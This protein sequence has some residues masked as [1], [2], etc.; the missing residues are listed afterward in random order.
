MILFGYRRDEYGFLSNFWPSPF[1]AEGLTWPTVEHFFQAMKTEDR[2]IWEIFAGLAT[3][4]EAKKMGRKAH[5]RSDWERVKVEIMMTA[6]RHKYG[7]N[8]DLAAKLLATGGE[9]LHEDSPYD[10]I[11]GWR[12]EGK[13]LLGRCLVQVREEFKRKITR[14]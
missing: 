2:R 4:L 3:P 12:N 8:P 6:L 5:L 13:D 7:Q 1:K 11:W 10:K 9:E 14:Q